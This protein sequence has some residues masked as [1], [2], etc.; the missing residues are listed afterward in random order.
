MIHI[1]RIC[2]RIPPPSPEFHCAT[3]CD[4]AMRLAQWSNFEIACSW[5]VWE[6]LPRTAV[7]MELA[8]QL[9]KRKSQG[10]MDKEWQITRIWIPRFRS[11]YINH[12][13]FIFTHDIIEKIHRIKSNMTQ[14]ITRPSHGRKADTKNIR[15]ST[16]LSPGW[17]WRKHHLVSLWYWYDIHMYIQLQT[18]KN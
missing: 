18:I 15:P 1:L 9:R 8:I 6:T 4:C 2:R 5:M 17:N 16:F 14:D 11:L 12:I 3:L 13:I 10:R 7:R